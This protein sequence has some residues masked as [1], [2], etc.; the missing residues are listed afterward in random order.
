MQV[1]VQIKR[2]KKYIDENY[3]T[4]NYHNIEMFK[5]YETGNPNNIYLCTCCGKS[6]NI[7]NSISNRGADLIC[8][9]CAYKYYGGWAGAM[10]V[11][12]HQLDRNP[13]R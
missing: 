4:S 5:K 13:L 2:G 12:T 10:W 11:H 3:E 8:G 1:I 6:T 9:A 7:D